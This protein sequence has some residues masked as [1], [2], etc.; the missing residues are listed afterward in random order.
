MMT[1]I[2]GKR[3]PRRVYRLTADGQETYQQLL[4]KSFSEY[5]PQVFPDDINLLFLDELAPVEAAGYLQE[6]RRSVLEYQGQLMNVPQH[7]GP[8][9]WLIE[10]QLR[11]LAVE[12]EWLD[13]IIRRVEE[14]TTDA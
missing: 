2:F 10:H 8:A 11:H 13:E 9:T 3:P 6:R 14:K 1:R 5:T 7:S 12:A 4:R